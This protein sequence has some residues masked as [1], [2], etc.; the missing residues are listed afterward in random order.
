MLKQSQQPPQQLPLLLQVPLI[1]INIQIDH[2]TE[3]I[4]TLRQ[5]AMKVRAQLVLVTI[6]K[7]VTI[8]L[9]RTVCD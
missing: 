1:A 5:G 2:L 6:G 7:S 8:L 9:V 4:M 3:L